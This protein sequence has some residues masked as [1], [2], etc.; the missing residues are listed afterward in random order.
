MNIAQQVSVLETDNA[1]LRAENDE[2]RRK[3]ILLDFEVDQLRRRCT[4]LETERD[5][6]LEI[7][8]QLKSILDQAGAAIV[9]GMN[10][11]HAMRQSRQVEETEGNEP[12]PLF[13]QNG[14]TEHGE[15]SD[16]E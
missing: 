3:N 7:C 11:I 12:P 15:E 2:V 6:A 13:L 16:T 5:N 1:Q 14:H 9:H 4:K 8:N 10:R